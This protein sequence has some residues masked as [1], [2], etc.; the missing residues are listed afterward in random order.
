MEIQEEKHVR[1]HKGTALVRISDAHATMGHSLT[2]K[3]FMMLTICEDGL[4]FA[5]SI[6]PETTGS[7]FRAVWQYGISHDQF[8][9]YAARAWNLWRGHERE[10]RFPEWVLQELDQKWL[11]DYPSTTE[12]ALCITNKDYVS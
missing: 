2:A 5:G 4:A 6:P 9:E 12:S 10:A 1:L 11:V 3:R 7:Y 8:N